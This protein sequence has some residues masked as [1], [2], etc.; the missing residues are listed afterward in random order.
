MHNLIVSILSS[1]ERSGARIE[2]CGLA[3]TRC[4]RRTSFDRPFD[5]LRMQLRTLL[6][7]DLATL[8]LFRMLL[9]FSSRNLGFLA[10]HFNKSQLPAIKASF[11]VRDQSL[12]R[13]SA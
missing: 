12:S 3:K 2:G 9:Y 5:K 1:A 13:R 10:N 6:R 8:G 11:F 4:I 7:Y